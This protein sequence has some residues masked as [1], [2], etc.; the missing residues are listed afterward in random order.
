MLAASLIMMAGA[1]FILLQTI[2][3]LF[4]GE[5]VGPKKSVFIKSWAIFYSG[6][7]ASESDILQNMAISQICTFFCQICTFFFLPKSCQFCTFFCQICTFFLFNVKRI[8]CCK[9]CLYWVRLGLGSPQGLEKPPARARKAPCK[10][11]DSNLSYF[12]V[13]KG[14]DLTTFG[15]RKRCRFDKKRCR[16]DNF[17]SDTKKV[18]I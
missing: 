15:W 4:F 14:A 16:F 8:F 3:S 18:Q 10:G 5:N 12:M 2:F 9:I 11:Q 13:K 7:F 1:V 17:L 6:S